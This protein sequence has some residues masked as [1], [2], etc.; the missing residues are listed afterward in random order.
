M[1]N[2]CTGGYLV[3]KLQFG[4]CKFGMQQFGKLT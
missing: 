2:R 4:K 1:F 3:P